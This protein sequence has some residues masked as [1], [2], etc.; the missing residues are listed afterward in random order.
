VSELVGGA[1]ES[2]GQSGYDRGRFTWTVFA[3]L[4]SFG[5][6]NAVLGP[7]LPYL[8]T[9]EHVGY[10]VGS[11][12][13][14]AFAVG[15]G[16]AGFLASHTGDHPS[17]QVV[18]P[19]GLVGAGIAG[20]GVGYGGTAAAT[21]AA[22]FFIS[23]LGTSAMV[24]LWAVLADAHGTHRAVAMT[25]GEIAVS[26]GSIVP[27]LLVSGLAG[28]L[29]TW[30]FAFVLGAIFVAAAAALS[31]TVSMPAAAA[32]HTE[33]DHSTASRDR[34]R[35]AMPTLV[36]VFTVV[37]LEFGLSFWLAS[38]LNDSVGLNRRL[39]VVMVTGLYAANLAGRL[40][41]S[42]LARHIAA[43]QLLA[44]SL[45]TVLVGL[46]VLLSATDTAVAAI[47]LVIAGAGIGAAFPLTSSLH[48]GASQTDTGRALGQV[49][50]TASIGQIFGPLAAG[51]IAHAAGLR[52]GLLILPTLA[53]VGA[54]ALAWHRHREDKLRVR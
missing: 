16:L 43:N 11:L 3:A 6:L 40:T 29:L 17:R 4:G 23:F 1:D 27:A 24:R 37:G 26:L 33:S 39:A 36:I 20:L 21:I 5:V 41:A 12:H 51:A 52:A 18:I 2:A 38:Y 22:A 48:V 8:R 25:E 32:Q 10:L 53:I 42:R 19:A 44:G 9:A 46:P 28:S 13:Q 14:V 15:G 50:T 30:R 47:G 7:A 49:F 54:A 31:G 35:R 34:R 45:L